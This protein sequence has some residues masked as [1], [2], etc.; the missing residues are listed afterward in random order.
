MLRTYA[1]YNRSKKV[2]YLLS[3]IAALGVAISVVSD[4]AVR[5]DGEVLPLFDIDT[6]RLTLSRVH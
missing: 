1:L 6:N 5:F 2:L 4:L 3:T